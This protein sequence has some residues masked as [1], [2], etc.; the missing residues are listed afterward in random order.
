[1]F[2]NDEIVDI[3][4]VVEGVRVSRTADE[5]DIIAEEVLAAIAEGNFDVSI[6]ENEDATKRMI[7][8]E[9]AER[10]FE[11]RKDER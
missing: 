6:E 3:T 5:E 10:E 1:M 7:S 2:E 8:E 4:I 11:I 9:K